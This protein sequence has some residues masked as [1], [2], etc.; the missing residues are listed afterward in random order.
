MQPFSKN[1]L[2]VAQEHDEKVRNMKK[3]RNLQ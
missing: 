3:L 2:A 1:Y